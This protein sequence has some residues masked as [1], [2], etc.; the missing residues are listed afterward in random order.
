MPS[1]SSIWGHSLRKISPS[2]LFKKTPSFIDELIIDSDVIYDFSID[3][4]F[5]NCKRKFWRD[6]AVITLN[7]KSKFGIK[8]P[9]SKDD[10]HKILAMLIENESELK[11]TDTE[12]S[13]SERYEITK[14]NINNR[15]TKTY[16]TIEFTYG[17]SPH[18]LTQL[19]F[20]TMDD[21]N[22]ISA[23]FTKHKICTLNTKHI[24][25]K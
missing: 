22:F 16:S 23:H 10:F 21:Y 7:S 3:E 8:K 5:D 2:K 9:L 14:W 6:Q 13:L 12:I 1:K 15:E 19:Q 17:T 18:V 11:N 24:K 25:K 20:E 4:G